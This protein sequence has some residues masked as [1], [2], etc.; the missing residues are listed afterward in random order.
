MKDKVIIYD[1]NC[2]MCC[3]YTKV[4]T[5]MGMLAEDGRI[6]QKNV[7]LVGTFGHQFIDWGFVLGCFSM[8]T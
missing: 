6:P 1:D 7:G 5:Q 3:A 2:P 4:F 8:D